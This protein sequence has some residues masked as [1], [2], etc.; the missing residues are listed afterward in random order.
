MAALTRRSRLLFVTKPAGLAC[1]TTHQG[2]NSVVSELLAFLSGAKV[3]TATRL[4][5]Q[6]SGVVLC[7]L[8]HDANRRVQHIRSRGHLKRG[9][10]AIAQAGELPDAGEWDAPLGRTRDR[11]GRNRVRAHIEGAKPAKTRFRVLARAKTALLLELTPQTGRMH[12]LRAH[13]AQAGLPLLGDRLYGG[14]S[15]ATLANGRVIAL[16]RI[17]L[18]C[19][20]IDLPGIAAA[21]PIPAELLTLWRDLGGTDGDWPTQ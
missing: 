12:Q 21:A 11:A 13:A 8:G 7:T 4:D 20:R 1:E 9:Y 14:P 19:A 18:H 16:D 17:A 5:V 3:H 10:L 15:T 6:V 2:E